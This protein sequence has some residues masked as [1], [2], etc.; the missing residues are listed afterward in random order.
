MKIL[1]HERG[2]VGGRV[3]YLLRKKNLSYQ[4]MKFVMRGEGGG[5][6]GYSITLTP[7]FNTTFNISIFFRVD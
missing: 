4:I 5:G 2:G 6:G 1:I 3:V 7:I